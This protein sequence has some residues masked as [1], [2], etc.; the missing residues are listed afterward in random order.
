MKQ[1]HAEI[2]K[3][4]ID[5]LMK[6]KTLIETRIQHLAKD[7]VETLRAELDKFQAYVQ[8]DAGRSKGPTRKV[9][10]KYRDPSSGQTWTGRGRM[11]KWM[12][13]QIAAGKDREEFLIAS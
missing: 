7:R 5:D 10:P 1:L 11:P 13:A 4:S 9:A 3:L 12:E 6:A 8:T 2:E